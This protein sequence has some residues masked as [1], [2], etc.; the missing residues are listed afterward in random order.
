MEGTAEAEDLAFFL[1]PYTK[2]VQMMW[3]DFSE[4]PQ[5]GKQEI[6]KVP[7]T[8]VDL[9]TRKIF[10][11]YEVPTSDNVKLQLDGTIFWKVV[12]MQNMLNG[13]SDPE[14]D[15]WHHSR[16]ALIQAV[17]K[18]SLQN[19]MAHFSQVSDEALKV[20]AADGF[21]EQRG[22]ELQSMEVTSFE[23]VD[24]STAKILQQII[25]ETTNRINR[26]QVQESQNEVRAASMKA[27]IELEKKR[28]ALIK[29]KAE[30][31]RLEA[32][33]AGDADGMQLMRAAAS[34]IGGLNES[35]PDIELRT[36]LYKMHE[37]LRSKNKDTHNLATG[38]AKMF[39]T[40]E[41][42]NLKSLES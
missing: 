17:S 28:T 36:E 39:L 15:V 14:G 3:S 42:V 37:K 30:N 10:F 29:T 7:V 20:Q 32:E 33:M 41:D 31:A 1:P 4:I 11:S 38:K 25:Q 9:R 5:N 40:P 8:K 13:T 27:E 21:Y 16:S 23:C 24:E 34:F 18:I 26:L 12:N 6:R 2:I 22:V 35:V 19:F